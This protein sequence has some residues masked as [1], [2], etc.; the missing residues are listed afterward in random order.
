MVL[1]GHDGLKAVNFSQG[2]IPHLLLQSD[3]GGGD[4]RVMEALRSAIVKT[5][6]E[7]FIGIDPYITRKVTLQLEI[8]VSWLQAD[9]GE[10]FIVFK[11]GFV[12]VI[13]KSARGRLHYG[14]EAVPLSDCRDQSFG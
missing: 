14:L 7:F 12:V 5:E 6:K 3:L 13:A 8:E 4:K 9:S 11:L 2:F 10:V 1:D